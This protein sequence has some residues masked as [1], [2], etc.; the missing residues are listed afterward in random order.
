MASAASGGI[1][2][3]GFNKMQ[4]VK[5]SF[6][7]L[8]PTF[9][10]TSR[11]INGQRSKLLSA[12]PLTALSTQHTSGRR[13]ARTLEQRAPGCTTRR[14]S[15]TSMSCDFFHTRTEHTLLRALLKTSTYQRRP[16]CPYR[17]RCMRARRDWLSQ[18]LA[19]CSQ[20]CCM[21]V[22]YSGRGGNLFSASSGQILWSSLKALVEL[23]ADPC[24]QF[25]S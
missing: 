19:L 3:I 22:S 5:I 12:T 10:S 24:P 4:I 8:H 2:K 6:W 14:Q 13:R 15:K 9:V 17:I 18:L 25:H 23:S 1:S 7:G 16:V 11:E 20:A 21:E